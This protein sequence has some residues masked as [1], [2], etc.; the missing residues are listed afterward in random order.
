MKWFSSNPKYGVDWFAER[1]RGVN[2]EASLLEA[3]CVAV[4][5]AFAAEAVRFV[6]ASDELAKRLAKVLRANVEHHIEEVE[7]AMFPV[8]EEQLGDRLDQLGDEIWRRKEALI[9]TPE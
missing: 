6:P 2:D 4:Q 9:T 3:A 7:G 5:E 8:A 1:L